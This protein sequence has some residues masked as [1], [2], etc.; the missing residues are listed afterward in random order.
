MKEGDVLEY[1]STESFISKIVNNC[2]LIYQAFR[3]LH[4]NDLKLEENILHI[5][6]LEAYINNEKKNAGL[7]GLLSSTEFTIGINNIIFE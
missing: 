3:G 4:E 5:M 7:T 1:Q 2:C 6:G